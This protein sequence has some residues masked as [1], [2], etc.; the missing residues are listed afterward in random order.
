M[1][2][3]VWLL[4]DVLGEPGIFSGGG[5][6]DL[7]CKVFAGG[8]AAPLGCDALTDMTP[9]GLI[10]VVALTPEQNRLMSGWRWMVPQPPDP[11]KKVSN[12]F[13]ARREGFGGSDPVE[14]AEQG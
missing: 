8:L 13:R 3:Q 5:V 9:R 11:A 14:N 10:S 7:L 2:L 12:I 1:G 4:Q 6:Q